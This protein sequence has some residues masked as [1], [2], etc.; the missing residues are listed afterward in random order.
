MFKLFTKPILS[1][2]VIVLIF[3][4]VSCEKNIATS[5]PPYPH[6]PVISNITFDW[7]TI[8]QRAKGSDNFPIT[9]ADDDHQYTSWGDGGGF[10]GTNKEGRV[11]LGVARIEGSKKDYRGFNVFGGKSPETK[12]TFEGKSYGIISIGGNLYM[13]VGPGSGAESFIESRLYKSTNHGKSWEKAAW[14]F[15]NNDKIFTPTFLQFGKDYDGDR[16]SYVYIYA[17]ERKSNKWE[18]Q[19]PGE[20]SLWRVPK[21]DI[22]QQSKSSFFAGFDKNGNPIWTNDFTTRKPVFID[23]VNGI[24]RTSVSYNSGIGRY[25]LITEHTLKSQGNIGIYDAPE[26]W[27]PWTTVLFQTGW[28]SPHIKTN[29][30]F[31][32]FSNK[33][34]SALY[35]FQVVLGI[36]ANYLKAFS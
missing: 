12:A 2:S 35:P 32:N 20:I 14:A 26:P 15:V 36:C 25:L 34:L 22:M 10:G 4:A 19:K 11:S 24:M 6:S 23:S 21:T 7:S 8:D 30:F 18:V 16:D 13:W 9:W 27:G 33:W 5:K 28:G 17:P 1:I 3:S 29:T 31:W